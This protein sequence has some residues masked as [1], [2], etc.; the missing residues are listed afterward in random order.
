MECFLDA[1]TL[2]G[3]SSFSPHAVLAYVESLDIAVPGDQS[4]GGIITLLQY[5]GRYPRVGILV[6]VGKSQAELEHLDTKVADSVDF[7][8]YIFYLK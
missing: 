4:G 3:H 6:Q 1:R 5:E 2:S 8:Y 7:F